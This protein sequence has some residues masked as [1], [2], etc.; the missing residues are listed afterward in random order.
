MSLVDNSGNKLN[1]C[2]CEN[3]EK[4]SDKYFKCKDCG[5]FHSALSFKTNLNSNSKLE[6]CGSPLRLVSKQRC[7]YWCEGCKSLYKMVDRR[8]LKQGYGF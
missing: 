4:L 3:L 7:S 2:D 8:L 1:N 5:R 6:C